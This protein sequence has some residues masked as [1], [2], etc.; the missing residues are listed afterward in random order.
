L[1]LPFF[2]IAVVSSFKTYFCL[3]KNPLKKTQANIL[4]QLIIIYIV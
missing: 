1:A 4:K 2:D 3:F